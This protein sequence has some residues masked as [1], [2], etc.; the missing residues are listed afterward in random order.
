MRDAPQG[1]SGPPG[2][3]E[4]LRY[5][6]EFTDLIARISTRLLASGDDGLDEC[7]TSA[8]GEVGRF[9]RLGRC[10]LFFANQHT[11]HCTHEWCAAGVAP[12]RGERQS[13]PS[14]QYPWWAERLLAGQP[15]VLDTLDQLPPE[16]AADRAGLAGEGIVSLAILPVVVGDVFE[17]FLT[18]E[19]VGPAPPRSWP[20][21]TLSLLHLV[22]DVIASAR[23]RQR[24]HRAA[25]LAA[26]EL[27]RRNAELERSNAELEN[28]AY[29]ASH[30]L[31]SPLLMVQ[32][33]LDLLDSEHRA[34]LDG[35][36]VE[37][38]DAARRSVHRSVDLVG[39][40]LTY[41][42]LSAERP[43]LE[44]VD[45][46][47]VV[48]GAWATIAA[49]RPG[50][51]LIVGSLPP[52]S[53]SPSLLEQ[54]FENLLANAVKFQP[55]GHR[56][57]VWVEA[58]EDGDQVLVEV[59]DDGIGII[60]DARDAV[61]QMFT[62]LHK[63]SEYPGTGIGLA[64]CARIIEHHGGRIWAAEAPEGGAAICFTLPAA[65]RPAP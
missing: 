38:L 57:T 8:L 58:T 43:E 53:A 26:E 34:A 10:T 24:A 11:F 23:E 65:E 36:G 47:A 12:R 51:E 14:A 31:R 59:R 42:R 45:L 6:A 63:Q 5:R 39:D 49:R 35:E 21:V 29:V 17:G 37:L 50:D 20:P 3:E 54:V 60:A 40:L 15:V 28:F 13:L 56:A 4:E 52:V 44:A 1:T 33:S 64:I 19:V 62:R 61:F 30:D 2:A 9:E 27:A 18:C 46:A 55:P 7:I 32:S 41:A 25:Q 22:T 16:L 48:Q